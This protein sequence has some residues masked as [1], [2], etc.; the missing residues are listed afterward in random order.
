MEPNFW[1]ERWKK[2]EIGWH[3]DAGHPSLPKHAHVLGGSKVLVPLCGK[4]Q[5][6]LWLAQHGYKVVGAELSPIACESFFKENAL[7]YSLT[8][9]GGFIVHEGTDIALWCGNFFELPETAS[10]GVSAIYDRAALIALPQDLRTT[11]A[12]R[13]KAV[14]APSILLVAFEYPEGIVTGPPFSV[15][16]AEVSRLFSDRYKITQLSREPDTFLKAN[17]SKWNEVGEIYECV[18]SLEA[19]EVDR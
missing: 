18:Y 19:R 6:M 9:R 5:D 2:N 17:I 16:E 1:N 15:T 8:E 12:K 4:S 13:L 11:Y 7:F 3:Q 10:A 14:S